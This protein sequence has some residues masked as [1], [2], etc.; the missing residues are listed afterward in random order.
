M[1]RWLQAGL[2]RVTTAALLSTHPQ[3]GARAHITLI[4][5][6]MCTCTCM[7]AADQG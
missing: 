4:H 2:Q 6:H 5:E 7:H 1:G 3:V